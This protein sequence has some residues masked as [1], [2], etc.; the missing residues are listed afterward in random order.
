MDQYFECV[1]RDLGYVAMKMFIM[2]QIQGQKMNEEI[3]QEVEDA[4]NKKHVGYHIQVK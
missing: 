3:S 1:L 4:W 2:K